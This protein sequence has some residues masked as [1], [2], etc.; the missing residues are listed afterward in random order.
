MKISM[1]M[2][3]H[4][5]QEVK[6]NVNVSMQVNERGYLL[7]IDELQLNFYPYRTVGTLC[8]YE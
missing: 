1:I 5:T 6:T 2:I 7:N 4:D 8:K 3:Y